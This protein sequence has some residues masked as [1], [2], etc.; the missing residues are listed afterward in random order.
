MA[1]QSLSIPHGKSGFTISDWTTG[2]LAPNA[3][4]IEVRW[5]TTDTNSK[6][7]SR[8]DI[9]LALKGVI[10]ELE[11]GGATVNVITLAGNANAPPL[12]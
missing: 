5:N 6:N 4:D 1:A 2:T 7:I 8:Y 3:G 11:T 10:R 9:V 12:V